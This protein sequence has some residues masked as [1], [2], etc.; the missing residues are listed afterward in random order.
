MH[1]PQ[2]LHQG[3]NLKTSSSQVPFLGKSER[4]LA[5]CTLSIVFCNLLSFFLWLK[6]GTIYVFRERSIYQS[7]PF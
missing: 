5:H 2:D 6:F 1:H 3:W 7:V 4:N